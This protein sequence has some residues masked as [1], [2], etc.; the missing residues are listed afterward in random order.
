L[1]ADKGFRSAGAEDETSICAL[2]SMMIAK[3]RRRAGL[4][5]FSCFHSARPRPDTRSRPVDPGLTP[6]R[7]SLFV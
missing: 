7:S 1:C 5:R 3:R 6:H 2:K 4:R